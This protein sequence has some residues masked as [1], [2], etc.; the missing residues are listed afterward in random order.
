MYYAMVEKSKSYLHGLSCTDDKTNVAYENDC[1]NCK[2][3]Y[4]SE[5]KYRV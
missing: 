5:S 2:A 4:F 3:V 1:A